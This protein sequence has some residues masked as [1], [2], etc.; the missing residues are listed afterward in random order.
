MDKG[1]REAAHVAH[2]AA[3]WAEIPKELLKQIVTYVGSHHPRYVEQ[4]AS[5]VLNC[6]AHVLA[7]GANITTQLP[8]ICK[9]MEP[10]RLRDMMADA[11]H[12]GDE[13]LELVED[14]ELER[15][16]DEVDAVSEYCI[17]FPRVLA[18]WRLKQAHQVELY[19]R[20]LRCTTLQRLTVTNWCHCAIDKLDL[21]LFPHL[22]CL[23]LQY[24]DY[25]EPWCRGGENFQ[26]LYGREH[27][28]LMEITLIN[29]DTV[30]CPLECVRHPRLSSA[31]SSHPD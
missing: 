14:E 5:I 12:F 19:N 1:E 16:G 24:D 8:E 26:I 18:A 31:A 7:T 10:Q 3:P 22:Q 4:A 28:S 27:A 23:T 25:S 2:V 11:E 9:S 29:H 6:D 17:A 15:V 13:E 30:S 21:R 20:A